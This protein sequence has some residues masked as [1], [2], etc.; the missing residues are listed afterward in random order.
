MICPSC[1]N[2]ST[3][4]YDSRNTKNGRAVRR[5]REC[6]KC[7]YRFTT[8]E[9]VKVLDLMVEKRSGQIVNFSESKLEKGIRKAFNKRRIDNQKINKIIQ[10]VIE[11]IVATGKN[12]V[13]STRIGKIVLKNLQNFD[14]AAYVCFWAMYGNFE[15]AEEFDNLLKKF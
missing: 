10:K 4:V 13:K 9:E 5:R 14:E 7:S 8:L 1:G 11:D 12:P 15:T 2:K 6:L 3:K